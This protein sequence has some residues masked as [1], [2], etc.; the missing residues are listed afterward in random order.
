MNIAEMV[1]LT[2]G[3]VSTLRTPPA[4][5]CTL[6]MGWLLSPEGWGWSLLGEGPR[7]QSSQP[8][9][10]QRGPPPAC[11][12]PGAMLCRLLA[13]LQI[14]GQSGPFRSFCLGTG[15]HRYAHA[16]SLLTF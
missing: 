2:L 9:A 14:Y 16:T 15:D 5:P 4:S 13:L 10:A 1:P 8:T 7:P 3:K 6:L 12:V 11:Q